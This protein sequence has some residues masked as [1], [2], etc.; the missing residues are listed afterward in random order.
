MENSAQQV[1]ELSAQLEALTTVQEDLKARNRVLGNI[2]RLTNRQT[3][4]IALLQVH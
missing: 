3:A 4:E 1:A 2:V